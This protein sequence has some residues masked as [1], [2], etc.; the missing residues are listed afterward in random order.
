VA[1]IITVNKKYDVEIADTP[2]K[3]A[4]GL[5]F[6]KKPKNI[7]F[8]FGKR[9]IYPIHSFFVFQRFD[10]LYLDE[11]HVVIEAYRSIPPFVPYVSNKKPAAYLLEMCESN[12]FNIGD[13]IEWS[14]GLEDNR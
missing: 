13:K 3:R 12:T 5:M 10:A 7:L 8:V 11:N 4:I 14:P 6:S 1:K 9:G 2:L